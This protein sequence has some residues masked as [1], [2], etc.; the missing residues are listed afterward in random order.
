MER[1]N[2]PRESLLPKRS[3]QQ[4]AALSRSVMRD[5]LAYN[6]NGGTPAPARTSG[7]TLTLPLATFAAMD[8][9]KLCEHLGLKPSQP[10]A[11]AEGR[12][13]RRR[14]RRRAAA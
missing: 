13:T 2:Y 4:S 12:D 5:R 7:A 11:N 3:R 6:P 14:R 10:H 9:G 1:M 8:F